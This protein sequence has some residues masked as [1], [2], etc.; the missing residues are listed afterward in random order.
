[1]IS[2]EDYA[3]IVERALA[4]DLAHRGDITSARVISARRRSPPDSVCAGDFAS[5]LNTLSCLIS[6]R[7]KRGSILRTFAAR[8]IAWRYGAG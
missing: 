5:G 8:S 7:I 3:P 1:M 2:V 4:E 6:A